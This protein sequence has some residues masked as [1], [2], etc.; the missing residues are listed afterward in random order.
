M[1]NFLFKDF[2][3][4]MRDELWNLLTL[5]Q[6]ALALSPSNSQKVRM[7]AYCASSWYLGFSVLFP[8]LHPPPLRRLPCAGCFWHQNG[9]SSFLSE[10]PP[11][12]EGLYEEQQY[13]ELYSIKQRPQSF[14]WTDSL[15][16]KKKK[17]KS[18]L[19]DVT[20][21]PFLIQWKI[22]LSEKLSVKD[23]S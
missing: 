4:K 22:Y 21:T 16:W 23:I 18:I 14:V 17:K 3:L 11:G 15:Q 10:F 19:D 5:G 12:K 9:H 20:L 6:Y 2:Q 8:T 1:P 13:L 7:K